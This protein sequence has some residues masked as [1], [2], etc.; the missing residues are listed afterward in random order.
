MVSGFREMRL[1]TGSSRL[2]LF[3]AGA[4]NLAAALILVVLARVAPNVLAVDP[5]SGSQLLYVDLA[6]WLVVG[7]GIGYL[8]AG[9]DLARFW[10][11]IALGVVGKAGVAILAFAY[12]LAGL[13]GPLVILLA[14]CDA[15]FAIL[16]VRLLRAHA[17]ALAHD[18]Q[19]RHR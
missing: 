6:A 16:F 18:P 10:P 9:K 11:I 5:L 12:F 17:T 13:T 2:L 15:L 4:F 7:F 8:L 1:A 3:V 19:V 14:S